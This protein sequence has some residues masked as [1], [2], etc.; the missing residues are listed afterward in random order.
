MM[1]RDA[2]EDRG[3]VVQSKITLALTKSEADFVRRHEKGWLRRLVIKAM[4]R[5]CPTSQVIQVPVTVSEDAYYVP[6]EEKGSTS[7][8]VAPVRHV[9]RSFDPD[10]VGPE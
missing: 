6:A 8:P 2:N 9:V 5:E 4:G 3:S 1:G 7:L 10:E